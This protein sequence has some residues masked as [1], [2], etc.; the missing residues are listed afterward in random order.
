MFLCLIFVN[1]S[2]IVANFIGTLSIKDL[3]DE[4]TGEIKVVLFAYD[5]L[6]F[7][8][9]HKKLMITGGMLFLV[10]I[11][12]F[13]RTFFK[14]RKMKKRGNYKDALRQYNFLVLGYPKKFFYWPYL[15]WIRS[16]IIAS[17]LTIIGQSSNYTE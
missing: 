6:Q 8:Y 13:L 3:G 16:L 9:E 10:V 12:S 1:F 4:D 14:I 17:C 11:V 7:S 15:I 5:I 2:S